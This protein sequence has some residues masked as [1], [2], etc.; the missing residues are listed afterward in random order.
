MVQEIKGCEIVGKY[1]KL[2]LKKLH[3]VGFAKLEV[4][5]SEKSFPAEDLLTLSIP[6]KKNKS[7]LCKGEETLKELDFLTWLISLCSVLP[8]TA[9]MVVSSPQ[10]LHLRYDEKKS[11]ELDYSTWPMI[12]VS[13]HSAEQTMALKV[14]S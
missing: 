7:D 12:S 11:K 14:E 5:A 10:D 2:K 4:I 6:H 1:N 3:L 13:L 8:T 9:L